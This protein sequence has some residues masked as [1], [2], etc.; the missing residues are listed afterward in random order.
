MVNCI[1]PTPGGRALVALAATAELDELFM[2][3]R[4]PRAQGIRRARSWGTRRCATLGSTTTT[5]W[6]IFGRGIRPTG[7]A[8]NGCRPWPL[9]SVG[10]L[11]VKAR[12]G[13]PRATHESRTSLSVKTIHGRIPH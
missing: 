9:V 5:C 13:M 11:S 8:L 7:L 6:T 10:G 3:D 4:A 2:F 1:D 12:L